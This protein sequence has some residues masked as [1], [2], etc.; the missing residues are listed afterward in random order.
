MR[1]ASSGT[2]RRRKASRQSGVGSRE[3]PSAV[4]AELQGDTE[5]V[6]AELPHRFLKFVL[7]RRADPHLIRLDRGL[8][9]LELAILD[10]LDDLAR[11]FDWDSLL[12]RDQPPHGA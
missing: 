5:V 12:N 2:R 11:R 1:R 6:L 3:S 4:V 7:R 10:E 8:D 9:F